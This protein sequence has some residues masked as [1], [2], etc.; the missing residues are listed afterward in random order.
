MHVLTQ[1]RCVVAYTVLPRACAVCREACAINKSL[2]CLGDV[3]NALSNKQARTHTLKHVL[4]T[5]TNTPTYITHTHTYYM[6]IHA[7]TLARVCV[8]VSAT[9]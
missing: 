7:L 3:F 8:C 5:H 2:S 6:H 1:S 9:L 4:L